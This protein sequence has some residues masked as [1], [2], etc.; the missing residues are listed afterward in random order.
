MGRFG[1]NLCKELASL[2]IDVLAIDK[3]TNRIQEYNDIVSQTVEIDALDEEAIK[4]IGI[5]NFDSVIVSIGEDLQA[6]ILITLM[7]KELGIK[8][9]WV[10]ARNEHHQKVLEK[11][12]ADRVIHPERDMARRIA[13][14]I[15]SDKVTDYIELSKDYSMVEIIASKKLA[16][17]TLN[18]LDVEDRFN[19]S[20]VAIKKDE[21]TIKV[22]PE[23]DTKINLN[24]I[25]ITIGKNSDLERFEDERV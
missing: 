4:S 13:H 14:H 3:D 6:S 7:L 5:T 22:K 11:I 16:G 1:G 9:V 2:G 17:K 21:E 8:Q 18:E 23:S 24:D 12:G 25:L 10:K 15:V 19:C 20:I